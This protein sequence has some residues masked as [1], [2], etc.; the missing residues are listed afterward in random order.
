MTARVIV[1]AAMLFVYYHIGG[2]ATTNMLRLTSGNSLPI[3]S[4]KCVC[5][6]CGTKITPFFQSRS[7]PI[8]SVKENVAAAASPYHCIL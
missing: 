7:F 3:N 6:N 4:S 5:D 1:A 8:L 2:L